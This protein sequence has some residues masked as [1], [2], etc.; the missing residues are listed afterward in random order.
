MSNYIMLSDSQAAWIRNTEQ[1]MIDVMES[2]GRFTKPFTD[3]EFDRLISVFSNF[4]QKSR[5]NQIIIDSSLA[6]LSYLNE[7]NERLLRKLG[8]VRKAEKAQSE[9]PIL[10]R[11]QMRQLRKTAGHLADIAIAY[12]NMSLTPAQTEG[13][14]VRFDCCSWKFPG[15]K[16]VTDLTDAWKGYF[17]YCQEQ[18]AARQKEVESLVM[19]CGGERKVGRSR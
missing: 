2:C 12:Q 9:Y 3:Q 16:L 15:Q 18:L 1:K 19:N 8:M 17:S 7:N 10:D 5:N 14:M 13:V 4:T 11:E 6:Y